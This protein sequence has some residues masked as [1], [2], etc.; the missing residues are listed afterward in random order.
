MTTP[1]SPLHKLLNELKPFKA[2][3][4]LVLFSGL[5]MSGAET[6]I[7]A[8]LK[9]LIDSMQEKDLTKLYQVPLMIFGLTLIKALARY[10]HMSTSNYM[11]DKVTVVLRRKM[12]AKFLRL[13]LTFHNNFT[14]GSGGLL[15]RSLND[16]LQIQNGLA[17]IADFVR[18]PIFLAGAIGWMMWLDWKLTL[19]IFIILPLILLFLQSTA[20]S[21]RKY[22]RQGQ[23]ELEGLTGT[24][25]ESLD[26]LRVIQSF[27]LEN[28][29]MNRFDRIAD[30]Y[31]RSRKKVHSR[32]EASGP[33]TETVATVLVLIIY[34]YL[35]LRMSRGE[36]TLGVFVS[37]LGTM[38]A[39]QRPIKKLQESYVKFQQTLISA[40]RVYSLLDDQ[41]EVPEIVNAKPFPKDWKEIEYRNVN[42]KY[43]DRP[44]LKNFNMTIRRGEI[45]ALVGESGSG[46]STV[47]NLLE[48]FFDPTS[49][50]ILVDGVSLS[51]FKLEDVRQNVALVTQ[52][53]FL[54]NDTIEYNIHSGD[55]SKGRDSIH[56]SARSANAHDFILETEKAYQQR[57]G[58]RGGLLSG[59][60][61]QRIS[62][63]RAMLKDAPI[64]ILDEATSALDSASEEEVQK[65][66]E[67][68]MQGRTAIVIAHR[69]STITRSNKIVVMKD[70]EIIEQG[71]HQSLVE[72]KGEYFK[73]RSLQS[74]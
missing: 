27:N 47:V 21:L 44:I 33:V 45:V 8:L 16:I 31:L 67:S 66:L 9:S 18:E 30:I 11:G 6:I 39:M 15:S 25:K 3:I 50:E 64:L 7:L 71:T 53:V 26:G 43:K 22:G 63:A 49:G 14:S 17:L 28:T 59:G 10:F 69:L 1:P 55:F 37:Y 70:G 29:M 74:T 13:N 38:L 20:R 46:K 48:R 19:S 2:Q 56:A 42:F 4:A 34:V 51:H 32:A 65:G 35:G 57:V 62:I 23:N 12:Q 68:L 24:I 61:K 36:A 41:N 72:L 54:F 73:F 52:D 40:E 58:D 5:V 60:E